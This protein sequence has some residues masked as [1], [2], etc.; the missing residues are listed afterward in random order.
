MSKQR[1]P[2]FCTVPYDYSD[3]P[4]RFCASLVPYGLE[5]VPM[6]GLSRLAKSVPSPRSHTH[7]G[8]VEL[9]LSARGTARFAFGRAVVDVPVHHVLAIQ[10]TR[11]HHRVNNLKGFIFFSILVRVTRGSVFP[12]MSAAES[13][14]LKRSLRRLPGRPFYAGAGLQRELKQVQELIRGRL[15]G[16]LRTLRIRALMLSVLLELVE[17]AQSGDACLR[18]DS[19]DRLARQIAAMRAHPEVPCSIGGIAHACGMSESLVHVRFKDLT[20]ESPHQFLL[21]LRL[22]QALRE[23]RAGKEPFASI[24]RRYHFCSPAHFAHQFARLY[25]ATPREVRQGRRPIGG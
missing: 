25:G 19:I 6:F 5:A 16:E 8:C 7:P 24:A 2:D 21:R 12:G 17:N 11:E 23:V 22:E 20:D 9:I 18:R 1:H 3:S 14:W 15:S 13:A 4:D 10:P